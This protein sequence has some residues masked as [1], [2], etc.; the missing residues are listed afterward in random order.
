MTLLI[1][2]KLSQITDEDGTIKV[3]FWC[4][5]CD[6]AHFLGVDGTDRRGNG[7]PNWQWN[8]DGNKPTFW[9]SV[10]AAK[11]SPEHHCHSWVSNGRI[12]FLSDSFHAL[13]NTTVDLPDW[14]EHKSRWVERLL[15]F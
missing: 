13:K 3:G 10:D 14:D 6:T 7:P 5:G 4:P 12:T 1:G 15:T 11:D 2:T 9:P 8:K